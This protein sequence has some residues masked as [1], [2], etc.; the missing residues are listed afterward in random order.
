MYTPWTAIGQKL[1][2][3]FLRQLCVQN[4]VHT[5]TRPST[6]GQ[7]PHT[8]RSVTVVHAHPYMFSFMYILSHTCINTETLS[9]KYNIQI[10]ILVRT[11][12]T[13]VHTTCANARAHTRHHA[14]TYT[15]LYPHSCVH[16]FSLH[17]YTQHTFTPILIVYFHVH[18]FLSFVTCLLYVSCFLN[19]MFSQ[20]VHYS[21]NV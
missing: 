7:L 16:V 9:H 11:Y 20:N 15:L 17:P 21:F 19:H 5:Y 10:H 6:H 18:G 3:S 12:L 4:Q 13:T 8:A 14:H 1:F 2:S